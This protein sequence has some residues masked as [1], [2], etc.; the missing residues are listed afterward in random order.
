M[1]DTIT[2]DI[3][4]STAIA[5][6]DALVENLGDA[7]EKTNELAE[8]GQKV[9]DSQTQQI[10]IIQ[11]QSTE[12]KT[13]ANTGVEALGDVGVASIGLASDILHV[14]H[15]FQS[16]VFSTGKE[17]I[18]TL[19]RI[20][21][22]TVKYTLIAKGATSVIGAV[23]GTS[24]QAADATNE[25]ADSNERAAE[26]FVMTA[27]KATG[28]ALILNSLTGGWK[29]HNEAVGSGLSVW[30]KWRLGLG[31]ASLIAVGVVAVT[32]A[33]AEFSEAMRRIEKDTEDATDDFGKLENAAAGAAANLT[34]P[35]T[36]VG[37][38]F[39]AIWGDIKQ[40]FG[41]FVSD[42]KNQ[43]YEGLGIKSAVQYSERNLRE[44][45]TFFE[46]WIDEA[47]GNFVRFEASA[48]SA[49]GLQTET[50]QQIENYA[51]EAKSLREL[52]AWHEKME[53]IRA[54][55]KDGFAALGEANR[56]FE[57]A[58][59]DR[60]RAEEIGALKSEEAVKLE[61]QRQRELAG[62]RIQSAKIS[63]EE[64]AAHMKRL[65]MI[66]EAGAAAA[67]NAKDATAKAKAEADTRVA[68][69]KEEATWRARPA[70]ILSKELAALE[71]QRTAL[72]KA[73]S[74]KRVEAEK[75]AADA[76][77]RAR[78][79]LLGEQ[80]SQGRA[81]ALDAA[82]DAGA[83]EKQL[84]EMR[85][86]WIEEERQAAVG[87]AKTE[88]EAEVANI[89]A[90]RKAVAEIEG[91]KRDEIKR[92]SEARKKDQDFQK[93]VAAADADIAR[94]RAEFADSM[95][96]HS[97]ELKREGQKNFAASSKQELEAE[98]QRQLKVNQEIYQKRLELIDREAK[99]NF[100]DAKTREEKLKA[101]S[102]GVMKRLR[103]EADFAKQTAD[104]AH[105][106][107]MKLAE[108][109]AR[110][111]AEKK[112]AQV[113]GV[114]PI[115]ESIIGGQTQQQRLKA[116]MDMRAAQAGEQ[117]KQQNIGL[118]RQGADDPNARR[119]FNRQQDLAEKE[120]RRQALI[121]AR[122][123]NVGADEQAAVAKNLANQTIGQMNKTGK[124]SAD[125][126]QTT[127]QAVQ[128][129]AQQQANTDALTKEVQTI[130]KQLDALRNAS[131]PGVRRAGF[132]GQKG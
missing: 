7:G 88:A 108:E 20:A 41:D 56:Q 114:K 51:Q 69:A 25:L 130:Q 111:A 93:S 122:Q 95:E 73:E 97:L 42:I 5:S 54:R 26:S 82:K 4:D 129:I 62:Q 34:R 123:G 3:D 14:E 68:I 96:L 125:M 6:L 100:D 43:A 94:A 98:R 36:E 10:L 112:A 59:K 16:F 77:K 70:E 99:R 83:N 87:A 35:F 81:T 121:D 120:A 72:V 8:A 66:E 37:P 110:K 23:R 24:K 29:S 38:A 90:Q 89:E 132:G 49:M 128:V 80:K 44:W 117:F 76:I 52:A 126:V 101:V 116:L 105:N 27:A 109:E 21:E 104:E 119:Q 48:R 63:P 13:F 64:D 2:I 115:A 84:H 102:D 46:N 12:W 60:Q 55:E 50:K 131:D 92:T 61:M 74:D 19:A 85:M 106:H 40:G 103:A 22:M 28:L 127:Q 32:K 33:G 107:K 1:A 11:K 31:Q 124:L 45:G 86:R 58:L 71:Q 78:E 9:V 67:A 118:F 39:D 65:Q 113:E 18:G 91:F 15:A 75:V 53:G 79:G 30:G 17:V 47:R 57:S